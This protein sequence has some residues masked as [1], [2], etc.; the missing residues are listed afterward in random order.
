MS[1]YKFT[2]GPWELEPNGASFN[3]ASKKIRPIN[4]LKH[5]MILL[6]MQHNQPG[7]HHANANLIVQAPALVEVVEQLIYALADW[8]SVST[9]SPDDIKAI[10]SARKV[11]AKVRG[12]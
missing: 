2:P 6:G 9:G 7:E 3:L 12:E 8:S 5:F 10:K 11:L 4:G 1:N